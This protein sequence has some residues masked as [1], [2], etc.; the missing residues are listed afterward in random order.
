[1]AAPATLEL[2]EPRRLMA[3]TYLPLVGAR[4]VK[5]TEPNDD[6]AAATAFVLHSPSGNARLKGTF[7]N[8]D[9]RDYFTFTAPRSGRMQVNVRGL[10]GTFA[11]LEIETLGGQDVFETQPNDGVNRGSFDLQ[12]GVTYIV[13]IE[14]QNPGDHHRYLARL[15]LRGGA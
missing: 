6:K 13:R 2:L 7:K 9:D 14:K 15:K 8:N 5:E 1:M 11:K 3:F 4:V 12:N 10:G